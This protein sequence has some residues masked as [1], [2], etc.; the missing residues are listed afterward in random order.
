MKE[1]FEKLQALSLLSN[2]IILYKG[3]VKDTMKGIGRVVGK[4]DSDLLEFLKITNGASILDY[5]FMGFKNKKLGYDI[6]KFMGDF[7]MSNNRMAGHFLPFMITSTGDVFGYLTD[8]V[9]MNGRHPIGYYNSSRDETLSIIGS[10]F[11][12]FMKTFLED[13]EETLIKNESDFLL[14]IV[15]NEWPLAIDHWLENDDDLKE[16]YGKESFRAVLKKS[17]PDTKFPGL[18]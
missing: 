16:L 15:K 7:W 2:Q 5:C 8:V 3:D 4:F 9:D 10:S 13:I 11:G 6:D 18:V 1:I 14:N 17:M 12:N